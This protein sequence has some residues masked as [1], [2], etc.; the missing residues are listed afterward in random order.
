MLARAPV[1]R[2]SSGSQA[3]HPR[4]LAAS[5][6]RPCKVLACL[7]LP[8]TGVVTV[9]VP[10]VLLGRAMLRA[11]GHGPYPTR[12]HGRALLVGCGGCALRLGGLA[13]IFR[14]V[15]ARGYPTENKKIGPVLFSPRGPTLGLSG[16]AAAARAAAPIHVAPAV[17]ETAAIAQSARPRRPVDQLGAK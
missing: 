9:H 3:V 10:C 1:P 16:R 17:A 13:V 14:V 8:T 4:S 7:L 15:C 11:G 6:S 12:R 2:P 5:R